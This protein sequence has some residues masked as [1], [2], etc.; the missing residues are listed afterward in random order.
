MIGC[1]DVNIQEAWRHFSCLVRETREREKALEEVLASPNRVF[2]DCCLRPPCDVT[3]A[4]VSRSGESAES[5]SHGRLAYLLPCQAS[6]AILC[7]LSHPSLLLLPSSSTQNSTSAGLRKDRLC[8]CD[9]EKIAR[10]NVYPHARNL[11]LSSCSTRLRGLDTDDDILPHAAG[12]SF[13]Q[14]LF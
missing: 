2:R 3:L 8:V 11:S 5:R 10:N 6:F 14:R 9:T 13:H 7:F 1:K 4:L 12:R